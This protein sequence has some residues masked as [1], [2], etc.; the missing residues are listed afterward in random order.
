MFGL[1]KKRS[2]VDK[3]EKKH[4]QL[5]EEAFR[6]SKVNRAAGDAKY[7]EAQHIQEQID[8]LQKQN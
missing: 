3:L 4:R 5:L 1:F 8:L 2:Q 7:A 6:L